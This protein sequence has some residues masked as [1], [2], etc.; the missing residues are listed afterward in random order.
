MA[1]NQAESYIKSNIFSLLDPHF[2]STHSDTSNYKYSMLKV[3]TDH[4]KS[5]K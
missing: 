1:L 2:C 3:N 4:K 5:W